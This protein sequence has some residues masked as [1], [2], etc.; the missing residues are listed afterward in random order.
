MLWVLLTTELWLLLYFYISLTSYWLK[1][2][3]RPLQTSTNCS[4][5]LRLNRQPLGQRGGIG[6]HFQ[7]L[8]YPQTVCGQFPS[9]QVSGIPRQQGVPCHMFHLDSDPATKPFCC[10]CLI[11]VLSRQWPCHEAVSCT[12]MINALGK[13]FIIGDIR[14]HS[15]SS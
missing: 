6:E 1:Y 14:W 11:R 13:K 7:L 4:Q 5:W 12:W 8:D 15:A 3:C 2:H 9:F 10:T